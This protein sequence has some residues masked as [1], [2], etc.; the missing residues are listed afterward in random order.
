MLSAI[1]KK[2]EG[3]RVENL[4]ARRRDLVALCA[5]AYPDL[6]PWQVRDACVPKSTSSGTSD[7]TNGFQSVYY[8]YLSLLLHPSEGHQTAQNDCELVQVRFT[9]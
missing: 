5:A 4:L 6:L 3:I 2:L 7:E 1:L 9:G 8:E